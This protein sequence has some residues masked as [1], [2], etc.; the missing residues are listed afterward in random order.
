MLLRLFS[1]LLEQ[2]TAVRQAKIYVVLI[3]L[4]TS[5]AN[6][7]VVTALVRGLI[8]ERRIYFSTLAD[9][10]PFFQIRNSFM[11]SSMS[12]SNTPSTSLTSYLVLVSFTKR[13]G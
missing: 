4:I 3:T 2:R 9:F 12:P 13:Y 6:F 10:P 8:C 11:K 7:H 5:R 1:S